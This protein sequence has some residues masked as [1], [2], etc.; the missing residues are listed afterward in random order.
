MSLARNGGN[1]TPLHLIKALFDLNK[2]EHYHMPAIVI[3]DPHQS[4]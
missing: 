1:N 3:S 2:L 4:L